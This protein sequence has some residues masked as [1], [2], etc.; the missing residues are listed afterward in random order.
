ML[1]KGYSVSIYMFHGGTSFGWMNGANSNGKNYEPD[2]T[3]YDY[4]SVLDE[5]GRPAAKFAAFQEG[6][7]K[8]CPDIIVQFSTGG[9][10]R[11]LDQRGSMLHLRT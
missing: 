7:R 5:S 11:A 10:G 1:S 9:R 4:D 8:H 6:I 2:V 3:S